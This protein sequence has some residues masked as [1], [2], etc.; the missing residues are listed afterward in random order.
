MSR[1]RTGDRRGR[2]DHG[3]PAV[4]HH[5]GA[6]RRAT[7]LGLSVSFGIVAAHEGTLR[8]EPRAG[9]GATF[10]V[11]LPVS[12][13]EAPE[14]RHGVALGGARDPITPRPKAAPAAA[15]GAAGAAARSDA[16]SAPVRVACLRAFSCSTMNRPFARSS[17]KSLRLARLV[18]WSRRPRRDA[19]ASC[20]SEAFAAV[21]VDH[22]M[23][24]MSGT[25]VFEAVVA[26]RPELASRFVFMSGDVLN[27]ELRDF[28]AKHAVALLA[29]PFDV[30]TVN[31][32]VSTSCGGPRPRPDGTLA[33]ARGSARVAVEPFA[34]FLAELSLGDQ[35]LQDRR[36]P[37]LLAADALVQHA[38]RRA[39]RTRR[40]R[41]AGTP[42]IAAGVTDAARIACHT[43]SGEHG[44]SMWVTPN[45]ASAST[46]AFTITPSAGVMPPS[47]PPRMPSG[48]SST[49]PRRAP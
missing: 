31:Q 35:P 46:T 36:R 29:K 47:P 3:F 24:G 5:E 7:G 33:P 41:C 19:V 16:S 9:G 20:R 2:T 27:P 17:P 49:A 48:W 22:R 15:A 4:L 6:R 10:I 11:E 45:S 23:P 30:D 34:G 26:V 40:S 14:R 8:F 39:I 38:A 44:M 21:L 1:R 12:A 32:M 43:R 37:E 25:D 18:L 42:R 13:R 28:A